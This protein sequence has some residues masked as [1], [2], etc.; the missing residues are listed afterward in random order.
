MIKHESNHPKQLLPNP[1]GS[2]AEIETGDFSM[3][4]GDDSGCQ[5]CGMRSRRVI[6]SNY[7][8]GSHRGHWG[9]RVTSDSESM[10]E[11]PR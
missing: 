2:R 6:T 4:Y 8:L 3:F 5:E 10:K 7:R 1:T 11:D 9:P